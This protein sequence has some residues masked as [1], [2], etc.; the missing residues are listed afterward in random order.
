MSASGGSKAIV[1]AFAA[2][3]GIAVAKLVAF[4][5]T[6]ATSMLAEA[7]HSLAD[8]GNQGL[9]L[10]GR[11][12]ANRP[13]DERHPFGHASERYFWAFV[14]ALVLFSM[15]GLFALYEG[16]QKLRQPHD[17]ESPVIAFGVLI[18]AIALEPCTRP[19][20]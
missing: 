7:I 20:R 15:G 18:F 13:P 1:A 14:V 8:S 19:S 4:L 6:G 2:N 11:R 3:V 9:L 5:L 17:L 16:V 12:K 10:L